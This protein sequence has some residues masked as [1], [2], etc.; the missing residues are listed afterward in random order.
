MNKATIFIITGLGKALLN[1]PQGRITGDARLLMGLIDGSASVAEI[2]EKVPPSVRVK[3]DEIFARLLSYGVIEEK[4]G[5]GFGPVLKQPKQVAKEKIQQTMPAGQRPNEGV[6][7]FDDAE[8]ENRR[9][10]ELEKELLEV[11]SKLEVTIA[12]QKKAEEDYLKLT[13]QVSA[14]VQGGVATP[15][16]EAQERPAHAS[17][18]DGLRGSLEHINQLN[19]ALLEQQEILGNTLKLRAYQAQLNAKRHLKEHEDAGAE[20][21]HAHPHYKS[22]RGLEF[23][24]CFSNAELLDFLTVAKWQEVAAG[25]TILSEGDVGMSF[26]IIVSGTVN[27]FRKGNMLTSLE[28]GDFFGEFAYLSGEEPV[29]SA[30]ALAATACEL[31]AVDPLDIEFSSVQLRLH[32][33]EALLRGQ[34]R[35][36][37]LSDQRIE[38]LSSHLENIPHEPR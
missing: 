7:A 5:A 24:K 23:F 4:A 28:R 38:R 17:A 31:L 27:I 8:I 16:K 9:R 6:P 29:R 32:V 13:Q 18:G 34:V 10:F 1:N 3:L 35:R 21:A 19:Q 20:T 36:T 25:E 2:A 26:Y 12:R 11:R 14:Y 15:A 37:L 30:H 22:L 33:V